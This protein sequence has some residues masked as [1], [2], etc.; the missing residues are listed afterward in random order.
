MARMSPVERRQAIV[1]AALAVALEKGLAA[2][3]VR[4]VAARMGTSSGLIHHYFESMD[5]VLA[6]AFEK[7]AAAD[8]A[9]TMAAMEWSAD[10]IDKLAAYLVSYT[11]ADQDWAF[12]VWL[13]AWAE[14]SRRPA[15]QRASVNLNVAWQQLLVKAIESGIEQGVMACPD[16]EAAAWRIL[17][18]Q[19]GLS[20]QVVAHGTILDRMTVSGW[21]AR[22]AEIELGLAEGSL[23][24]RRQ[25][26]GSRQS[27]AGSRQ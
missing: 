10:P 16:A 6:A 24:E 20:L 1:D 19:D 3:T 14:A 5:D 11:R 7:A 13:D 9:V 4:D 12:Q 17:S 21:V 23:E 25:W 2:T 27:A 26:V 15:V 8:L 18:L 22:L